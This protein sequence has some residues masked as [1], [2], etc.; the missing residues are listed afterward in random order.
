VPAEHHEF[1]RN[2]VPGFRAHEGPGVTKTAW[3]PDR[4]SRTR[5]AGSAARAMTRQRR[6]PTLPRPHGAKLRVRRARGPSPPPDS[7]PRGG[8]ARLALGASPEQTW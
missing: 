2:L 7:V 4:G 3:Q 8:L 6:T 1:C 5:R